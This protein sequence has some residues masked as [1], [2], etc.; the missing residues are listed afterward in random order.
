MAGSDRSIRRS[1]DE[2]EVF[3]VA[4][5]TDSESSRLPILIVIALVV[6]ASFAGVVWLAYEKG[7]ASGRGEPRLIAA[8]QGPAREA[9]DNPGGVPSEYKGLKIYQQAAPGDAEAPTGNPPGTR[10]SLA[11]ATPPTPPALRPRASETTAETGSS[12]AP[13][14]N[15]PVAKL[16]DATPK[17]VT[18]TREVPSKPATKSLEPAPAPARLALQAKPLPQATAA[19]PSRPKAS[20]VSL[21]PAISVP[22]PDAA[23]TGA[24]MLQIGSYKSEDE[25]NSAW[26]RAQ[27]AHSALAGL[28]PNIQ[29]VDLGAKGT[30]FRL[31]ASPFADKS[32][33][34]AACQ[35]VKADGGSCLIAK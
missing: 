7:V 33:A 14:L 31:R 25:A 24:Y 8:E 29:K 19:T 10:K 28:L 30:W 32:A 12:S 23:V 5:E 9:P 4:E 27:A 13:A 26:T 21:K 11:A 17:P 18:K 20:S 2:V 6:L 1:S 16:I 34:E 22:A 3:D 35:K 15:A